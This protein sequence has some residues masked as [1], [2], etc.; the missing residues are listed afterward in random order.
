M[1]LKAMLL[2]LVVAA[3]VQLLVPVSMIQRREKTL[4]EGE[5]F[6]FKTQPVDPYDAF[7]GRYVRLRY[8]NN[9]QLKPDHD[10]SRQQ[11][12]NAHIE[13]DEEGFSRFSDIS[14]EVP[15]DVPYLKTHLRYTPHTNAVV[16]LPFDR[17]Y[18]EEFEAPRAEKAY[19]GARVR[20]NAYVTV[21]ILDGFGVLEDLYVADVP[22]REYLKREK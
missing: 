4:R 20:S 21:R 11:K 18:L 10:F 2:I 7:R 17:M 22:I 5:V 19:A 12:V 13:V 3:V 6:K 14:R 8:Q 9:V 1:K 15:E 16:R